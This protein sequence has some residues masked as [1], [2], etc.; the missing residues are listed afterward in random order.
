MIVIKDT[1]TFSFNFDCPKYVDDNSKHE[2]K[3]I[4]KSNES[5]AENKI[6]CEIEQ[7]LLKF[8]HGDNI[9]EQGKHQKKWTA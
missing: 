5:S 8:K 9:Y 4:M 7:L 1:R 6:K 2:I 3:F